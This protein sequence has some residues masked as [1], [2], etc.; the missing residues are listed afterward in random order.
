MATANDDNIKFFR[1]L[2]VINSL[3]TTRLLMLLQSDVHVMRKWGCF[4]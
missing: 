3:L 2:H 1:E 4:T